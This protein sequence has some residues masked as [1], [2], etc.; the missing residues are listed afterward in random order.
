VLETT[1]NAAP[2]PSHRPIM[3]DEVLRF[4]RPVP[5]D[6]ALDCTL[7]GGGHAQAIL[8]RIQP[9]GRLIGVDVDPLELPRTTA[10]LRAAG[11]GAGTFMARHGSFADLQNILA[12]DRVGA[13]NIVLA[14]LGL[15]SMQADNA[16]RGFSYKVAGPLD[17]RMDPSQGEPA[18]Q[19]LARLDEEALASVLIENADEPHARLIAG[20][21]KR[22][23]VTTTH[24]LERVVRTGLGGAL[25]R[26]TKTEVK[27]S[28][29]RTFQALRI[30]VNDEFAAL[31]ALLQ[32][33]PRCLAPGGR[34][35]IL[36]FHSGE[37]RRVKKAFQAGC[38]AGVYSKVADEVVRSGKDETFANRRAS[39][40][41][42]RWAVRAAR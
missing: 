11:F 42:L 2:E 40:A 39:A 4:L 7:G 8:E 34:V 9:D 30:A 38:R 15:S 32:S 24:A 20:L 36:T 3:V 37:D 27:M 33:L 21:L 41:K 16:A 28:V 12:A 14:D 29:R 26:L 10:R 1:S 19:R 25:P 18:S 22:Q 23:P 5:G 6:A 35:V 13:V 31:D 17:M